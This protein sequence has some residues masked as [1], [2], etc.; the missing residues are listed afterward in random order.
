MFFMRLGF[1]GMQGDPTTCGIIMSEAQH[2]AFLRN[3]EQQQQNRS[4]KVS[5]LSS[6][7]GGHGSI[8]L[9]LD[10]KLELNEMKQKLDSV[11]TDL[12][13][14]KVQVQKIKMDYV[15]IAAVCVGVAIGCLM[16]KL[17]K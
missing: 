13:V 8:E 16:S 3:P 10:L 6:G 12:S 11:V 5:H 4:K 2:V 1:C 15:V 9:I 17:W 7:E 14:V